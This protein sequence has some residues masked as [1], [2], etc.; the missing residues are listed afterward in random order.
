M[1]NPLYYPLSILVGVVI[2]VIGVRVI[3][4]PSPIMIPLAALVV[5]AGAAWQKSQ[6]PETWDLDDPAL[7]T[8]LRSAKQQATLLVEKSKQLRAEAAR[9]LADIEEIDLLVA[10]QTAC[11]QTQGLPEKVDQLARSFQTADTLLSIP[12]LQKQ[13]DQVQQR[14][15]QDLGGTR[16]QLLRMADSLQHN[17]Q[18]TQQG[19]DARQAQVATLITLIVD[20]SGKMQELQNQLRISDLKDTNTTANLQH[21]S[22]T[23]RVL[24]DH[25]SVL[26][27]HIDA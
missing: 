21:L 7:E 23:L 3:H 18:V 14:I 8:E 12:I 24:Q 26:I 1:P 5:T 9:L 15:D 25:V 13:L 19:Q 4:A 20:A 11:D 17:I 16:D 22:Q 10:V 27:P 2:L 6:Q